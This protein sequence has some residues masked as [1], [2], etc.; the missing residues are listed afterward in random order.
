MKIFFDHQAFTFLNYGGIP[1]YFA[2]LASGLNRT[3]DNQAYISYL[4]SNNIHLVESGLKVIPFFPNR[5]FKGKLKI[6]TQANQLYS[7]TK[8]KQR[9]F[10]IFHPTYYD[11]YFLPYLKGRP[12]VVTFLDMIHERFGSQFSEL[13]YDGTITEQK[14]LLANRAERIIAISEST[15][16]DVVELLDINPAKIDVV[17]LG[18]SLEPKPLQSADNT[19]NDP[20]LLF[21]GNR[22]MYKNFMGLL[23]AIHPVLKK[24][25]VKIL[26]AGGGQF[27]QEEKE[28]I[29][30]LN[31]DELVEQRPINDQ[32][33]P[34]LYQNA[35]AFVFPS[36]YEGFGIPVLEAFACNCPCI[37]SNNSSLPEVAG[38]AALYID[39]AI[40][41]SMSQAVE[42]VITDATLRAS[43][44]EK[45]REQLAKFSWQRTVDETLQLYQSVAP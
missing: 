33:L 3:A 23:A 34:V 20:Y 31:V 18:S 30:S 32:T 1:R 8:L 24:Y 21:V 17:Y 26:C 16:R 29:H 9:E 7:I 19:A 13:A 45:G 14:R 25:K 38:D 28:F 40:P 44:I 4:F 36:L 10:D 11:P 42:N 22:S 27:R 12:F 39:P 15:K 41:E 6:L 43:L 35:L 5:T 2:E 37:V